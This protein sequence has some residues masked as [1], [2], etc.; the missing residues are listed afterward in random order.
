MFF[1]F[2]LFVCQIGI[3]GFNRGDIERKRGNYA[4]ALEMYNEALAVI[5]TT[6]NKLWLLLYV[7]VVLCNKLRNK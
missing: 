6:V 1:T 3:Y 7:V 2:L 5:R 4:V